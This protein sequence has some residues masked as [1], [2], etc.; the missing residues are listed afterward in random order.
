MSTN[1]ALIAENFRRFAAGDFEG[2]M[3]TWAGDA[4]WHILDANPWQGTHSKIDYFTK[5]LGEFSVDRGDYRVHVESITE[6]GPE[7]VVV[8]L[9]S[10]GIN[11]DPAGGLMIY[12]VVDGTVV[13]GWALSRGRDATLPF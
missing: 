12:R 5:V 7:L 2:V 11:I 13:E 4:L 6:F 8:H 10:T 3:S 9:R 1:A